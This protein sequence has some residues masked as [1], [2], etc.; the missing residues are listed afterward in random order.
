MNR[1][2]CSQNH[3]WKKVKAQSCTPYSCLSPFPW[4][5]LRDWTT[6]THNRLNC[7]KK[8]H[9][10]KQA[11]KQKQKP[12]NPQKNHKQPTQ[13]QQKTKATEHH[14]VSLEKS[15]VS[16]WI[17]LY[18]S[19]LIK[20]HFFRV[21]RSYRKDLN[22]QKVGKPHFSFWN[23]CYISEKKGLPTLK[24]E[25][26]SCQMILTM[27]IGHERLLEVSGVK[28]ETSLRQLAKLAQYHRSDNFQVQDNFKLTFGW[29]FSL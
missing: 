26:R 1:S 24:S 7:L 17:I 20:N 13:K 22:Y 12:K 29:S 25:R 19:G 10:N 6:S 23:P 3:Y 21:T 5:Q 28:K 2:I 8:K 15:V 9:T 18:I 16:D 4:T 27:I 14:R 11:K